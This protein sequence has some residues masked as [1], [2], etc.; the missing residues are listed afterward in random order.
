[1]STIRF[2]AQTQQYKTCGCGGKPVEAVKLETNW[3]QVV[4]NG[5]LAKTLVGASGQRYYAMPNTVTLDMV[6]TDAAALIAD[7]SVRAVTNVDRGSLIAR[8]AQLHT[9]KA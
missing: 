7:G 2:D 9:V 1:M 4:V 6:D 5:A 3:V 8:L